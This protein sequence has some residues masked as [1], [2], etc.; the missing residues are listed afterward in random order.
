MWKIEKM[1]LRKVS[2]VTPQSQLDSVKAGS[3]L[4]SNSLPSVAGLQRTCVFQNLCRT[5]NIFLPDFLDK[6]AI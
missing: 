1:L 4:I 2:S 5:S 3:A 6:T